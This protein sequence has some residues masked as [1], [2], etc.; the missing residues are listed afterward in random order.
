MWNLPAT[1]LKL[2]FCFAVFNYLQ[3]F[4]AI[5]DAPA[6][7]S[8][9]ALSIIVSDPFFTVTK[10]IGTNGSSIGFWRGL[11]DPATLCVLTNFI[12]E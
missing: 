6:P 10:T 4:S 12:L 11:R 1:V 3:C 8:S 2:A 5:S 9:K 7:E